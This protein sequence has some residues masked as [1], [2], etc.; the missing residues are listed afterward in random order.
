VKERSLTG[1]QVEN[2]VKEQTK[3]QI[4]DL[5]ATIE[6][7]VRVLDKHLNIHF[8]NAKVFLEQ[9]FIDSEQWIATIK[10]GGQ[11]RINEP[12]KSNF[13]A[14]ILDLSLATDLLIRLNNKEGQPVVISIDVTTNPLEEREKLLKIRGQTTK[15]HNPHREFPRARSELGIDKHCILLLN[16][17]KNKLPS[18]EYLLNQL[19]AFANSNSQTRAIN[20]TQVPEAELYDWSQPRRMGSQEMWQTFSKPSISGL[21][22][23]EN[24]LNAASKAL[25]SGYS[26]RAVES[27]LAHDP[28]YKQLQI[29]GRSKAEEYLEVIVNRAEKSLLEPIRFLLNR[30]GKLQGDGSRYLATKEYKISGKGEDLQVIR[31]RTSECILSVSSGEISNQLNHKDIQNFQDA[32]KFVRQKIAESQTQKGNNKKKSRGI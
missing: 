16:C 4:F 17:E 9:D 28:Q 14:A 7:I 2:W 29:H 27:M 30:H 5:P 22:G 23:S 24:S 25:L 26:R 8:S 1:N 3:D 21:S 31:I 15:A 6:R 12:T 32:A 11:L 20:L 19:D 13:K 18:R 10:S